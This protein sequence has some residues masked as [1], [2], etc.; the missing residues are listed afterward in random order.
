MPNLEQDVLMEE[1][2]DA[3]FSYLAPGIGQSVGRFCRLL[4][5][6]KETGVGDDVLQTTIGAARSRAEAAARAHGEIILAI[7]DDVLTAFMEQ[8]FKDREPPK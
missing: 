4:A 7:Q 6:A 2:E 8:H 5:Q 3:V 1:L